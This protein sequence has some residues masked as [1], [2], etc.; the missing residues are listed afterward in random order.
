MKVQGLIY[1]NQM[2]GTGT[3]MAD[4]LCRCPTEAKTM[5]GY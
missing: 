3:E 1:I 4:T 2:L 5:S